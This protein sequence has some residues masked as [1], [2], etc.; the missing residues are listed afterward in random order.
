L[1]RAK[2]EIE[3]LEEAINSIEEKGHEWMMDDEKYEQGIRELREQIRVQ[4]E[5]NALGTKLEEVIDK[6]DQAEPDRLLARVLAILERAPGN[7]K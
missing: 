7:T 5:Y 3:V 1:E 6:A 4:R 2:R